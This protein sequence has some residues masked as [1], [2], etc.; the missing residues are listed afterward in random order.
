MNRAFFKFLIKYCLAIALLVTT[1]NSYGFLIVGHRGIRGLAPEHTFTGFKM[2]IKQGVQ[3][4]DMDIVMTKDH[5]FVVYHDIALNPLFTRDKNGHWVQKRTLIKNLT[6]KELKQYNVGS[7]KPGTLYHKTFNEQKPLKTAR[8]PTL[9]EVIVYAKQLNPKIQFQIE[10]KTD[11]EHPHHSFQPDFLSRKLI[12]LLSKLNVLKD[13]RIQAFDWRCLY[14]IQRISP[15]TQTAYLTECKLEQKMR[16]KNA[17]IAGRWTGGKLLKD[18]QYSIPL[19]VKSLGG[20]AWDP[21]AHC[22]TASQVQEAKALGLQVVVWSDPKGKDYD[23]AEIARIKKYN[24]D[25]IITDRPDK[26][27]AY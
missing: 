24:I 5:Q 8:I 26:L 9:E 25:G 22:L 6:L 18:Y 11:P 21:E 27:L 2:A 13:S 12:T 16:D 15:K 17:K 23:A 4:L 3:V 14:E 20:K 7:I 1:I 10:I 19:M